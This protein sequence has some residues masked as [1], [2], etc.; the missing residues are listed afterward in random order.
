MS[1]NVYIAMTFVSK[2]Y[3]FV[4]LNNTKLASF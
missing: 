1:K 3:T 4:P 2:G